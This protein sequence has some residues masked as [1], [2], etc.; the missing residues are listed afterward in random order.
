[1][2]FSHMPELIGVLV[3]GLLIFGPK[4]LPEIGSSLGRGIRD[5]KRSVNGQD[6]TPTALSS[7]ADEGRGDLRSP[8]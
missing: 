5:F 8:V 4:R 1:M 2:F 7:S 3:I 6:E